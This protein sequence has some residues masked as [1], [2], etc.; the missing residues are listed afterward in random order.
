G[1]DTLRIPH[2]NRV[3]AG[4]GNLFLIVPFETV[5][6]GDHIG[7]RGHLQRLAGDDADLLVD[8]VDR[9]IAD[10]GLPLALDRDVSVG[11]EAI[12]LGLASRALTRA[13]MRS[14]GIGVNLGRSAFRLGVAAGDVN[15]RVLLPLD[16]AIG[17]DLDRPILGNAAEAQSLPDGARR[18]AEPADTDE[19]G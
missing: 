12:D 2:R 13:I 18:A 17:R 7:R 3:A 9:L 19:G 11:I 14:Q 1:A 6:C 4:D 5:A 15:L 16:T 10:H 8:I